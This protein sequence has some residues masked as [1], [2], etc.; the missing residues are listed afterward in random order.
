LARSGGASGHDG[1]V[2]VP[3]RG[4][5]SGT[6]TA[7]GFDPVAGIVYSHGESVGEATHVGR[8]TAISDAIIDVTNGFAM[9]TWTITAANGDQLFLDMTGY[10]IDDLHGAGQFTITGGT[11]RFE[12]AS[13][14]F[15][16]IATFSVPPGSAEVV[17]NTAVDEGTICLVHS[18][19][20]DD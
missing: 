19:G 7:V 10:G 13:G 15:D 4:H 5:S 11:G 2:S 14:Y 3:F 17:G 12:G 20:H 1:C 16:E 6:G 18:N 8:F 9:G